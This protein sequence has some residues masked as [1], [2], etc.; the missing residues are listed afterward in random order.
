MIPTSHVMTAREAFIRAL[1]RYV[2]V[3]IAGLRER[4]SE[5]LLPDDLSVIGG[6]AHG[7]PNFVGMDTADLQEAVGDERV[8]SAA[9]WAA[10]F[11]F[12]GVPWIHTWAM[13]ALLWWQVVRGCEDA[14]CSRSCRGV[15]GFDHQ[16]ALD[17]VLSKE[18]LFSLELLGGP[19]QTLTA[20][21]GEPGTGLSID[22]LVARSIP[23]SFRSS[24]IL[25]PQP[26]METRAEYQARVD[27]AWDRAL[28]ELAQQGVTIREPRRLATH[29]EWLVRH[30]FAGEPVA[31]ILEDLRAGGV[32]A[33]TVYKAIK[34]AAEVLELALVIDG[35]E[36]RGPNPVP[37]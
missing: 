3:A 12:A 28:A 14:G 18:L 23:G 1:A 4:A 32:D 11:G 13:F 10:E 34:G 20:T 33:S 37:E 35:V 27:S 24:P 2:P 21:V 36:L 16:R 30:K 6:L 15:D 22:G 31:K 29:C 26:D 5:A 17:L 7:E 19:R 25:G 9:A 8:L